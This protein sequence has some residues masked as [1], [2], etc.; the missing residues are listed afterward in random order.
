M[1]ATVSN[2]KLSEVENKLPGISSLV[3]TAVLCELV[4]VR[5][6]FLI[7]LNILLLKNLI[8]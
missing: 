6:K 3:N 2:T 5:T 8:S 4:K 1:T 7:M